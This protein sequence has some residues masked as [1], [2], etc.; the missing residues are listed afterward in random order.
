MNSRYRH[1]PSSVTME[2]TGNGAMWNSEGNVVPKNRYSKREEVTHFKRDME[3]LEW[4]HRILARIRDLETKPY[5]ELLKEQAGLTCKGK[6]IWQ[7]STTYLSIC[8]MQEEGNLECIC[9]S[10]QFTIIKIYP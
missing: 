6:K 1:Y 7:G 5:E 8:H 10:G 3:K 2:R 4:I 9:N